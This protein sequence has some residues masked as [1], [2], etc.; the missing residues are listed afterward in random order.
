MIDQ[1]N[2]VQ[3][4]LMRF[5]IDVAF[6]DKDYKVLNVITKMKSWSVSPIVSK[7]KYVIESNAGELSGMLEKGGSASD[8]LKLDI[9]IIKY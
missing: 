2:S 9:F 6:V 4:F 5:P 7:S 8:Y 3:C 1:C